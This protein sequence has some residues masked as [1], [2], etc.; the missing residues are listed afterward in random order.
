MKYAFILGFWLTVLGTVAAQ[1]PSP[2]ILPP[3]TQQ[4]VLTVD[5]ANKRLE[6][7]LDDLQ[8]EHSELKAAFD[9]YEPLLK[10]WKWVFGGLG[11]TGLLGFVFGLWKLRKYVQ[12]KVKEEVDSSITSLLTNRRKDF[13]A[14]LDDYDHDRRVKEKHTLVLLT[15]RNCSDSFHFDLLSKHGLLVKP[16]TNLDR[17]DEATFGPKDIIIINDEAGY[18]KEEDIGCNYQS[19]PDF[20]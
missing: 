11:I 6:A 3:S 17:L 8:K 20:K 7:K 5:Q 9:E 4:Q 1:Q 16:L 18:W 13:L 14:L 15:P 10:N 2:S 19:G 12:N